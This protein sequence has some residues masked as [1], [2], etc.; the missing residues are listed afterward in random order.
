[1]A[2]HR[3][4]TIAINAVG[5]GF[6]PFG[7]LTVNETGG[8]S[9]SF[10][11]GGRGIDQNNDRQ[12]A[13]DEGFGTAPPRT[14]IFF[15]DGIRQT[16]ADLMQLVRGIEVGVDVDGDG[17]P[18]LDPPRIYYFG[19][20]LGGNYGTVFLSV[21]PSVRAGVLTVAGG[22]IAQNRRLSPIDGRAVLGQ[23]LAS[24]IPSLIHPPGLMKQ[25][26]ASFPDVYFNETFLLRG[27]IPLAGGLPDGP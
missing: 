5:H 19:W 24:R 6:G 25:A 17:S 26:R 27:G 14:V 13:A 16:V 21:D 23:A 20:S 12:I 2:A 1:M 11:A 8:K 22:P 4:A 18:D 15:A 3:I 7:V 10:S 9:T